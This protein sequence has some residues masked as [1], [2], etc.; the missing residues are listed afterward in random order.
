MSHPRPVLLAR[1]S[2]FLLLSFLF[3]VSRRAPGETALGPATSSAVDGIKVAF[4]K[5]DFDTAVS[6]GEKAV[7]QSPGDAQL[8]LWLGRAYGRKAQAASALSQMS[9]ARKC[10]KAFEKAV[11][12]DPSSADARFDLLSFHVQAPAIAGGD[13]RI[14]RKQAD[15]L[16]SLDPVRGHWGL[17]WIA[18][19]DK[20]AAR[21]EVEFRK[22]L[23]ADSSGERAAD[24]HWRFARFLERAGRKDEARAEL[25][26]ALK[27]NPGHPAAKRDLNR[28]ES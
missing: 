7:A 26:E 3:S 24:T 16:L 20:D 25:R 13:K 27:L 21:A 22:A 14:A 5:G 6:L 19:R 12:L 28:L 2:F 23:E 1:R 9:L 11:S 10:R 17:A 8:Q 4:Q 18:E 15:A